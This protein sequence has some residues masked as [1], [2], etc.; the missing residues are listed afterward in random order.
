M[1]SSRALLRSVIA[2]LVTGLFMCASVQAAT[3]ANGGYSPV[4]YFTHNKAERG[5]AKFQATYKDKTYY[6][7]SQEQVD[8]FNGNPESYVPHFGAFCAYS[9]T[10]GKKMSID[11]TSFKIVGG[12]LLLFHKSKGADGLK[13]WHQS[14]NEKDLLE[15]AEAGY[16]LLVF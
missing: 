11:P 4:S 3:P 15:Q 5:D 1:F 7:T 10:E 6:L 9:L 2:L 12:M 13:K 14:G 8:L 16:T